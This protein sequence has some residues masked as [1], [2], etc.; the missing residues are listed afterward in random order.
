MWFNRPTLA[1]IH[2][3]SSMWNSLWERNNYKSIREPSFFITSPFLPHLFVSHLFKVTNH[4]IYE[5]LYIMLQRNSNTT[6]NLMVTY[7]TKW[8]WPKR[9]MSTKPAWMLNRLQDIIPT[10]YTLTWI[11]WAIQPENTPLFSSSTSQT[12][13]KKHPVHVMKLQLFM[14]QPCHSTFVFASFK[15][16]LQTLLY[17]T[18]ATSQY[19]FL[20]RLPDY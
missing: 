13:Q 19:L 11:M 1:Y 3:A 2:G 8:S 12:N 6:H 14:H 15:L 5:R 16:G 4:L 17:I 9:P 18:V 7:I 20:W 10:I